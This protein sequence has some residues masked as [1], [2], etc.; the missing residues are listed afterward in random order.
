MEVLKIMERGERDRRLGISD[1]LRWLSDNVHRVDR[2]EE[3]EALPLEDGFG[4]VVDLDG[5]ILMRGKN[6]DDNMKNLLQMRRLAKR[7]SWVV[8]KTSR[9]VDEKEEDKK[10]KK[11]LNFPM[12]TR[13]NLDRLGGLLGSEDHPVW[14]EAG[15][16]K[17][18][19][20]VG[21]AEEVEK[22]LVDGRQ[23]L[24]VGSGIFDSILAE[25]LARKMGKLSGSIHYVCV[26]SG[27][28]LI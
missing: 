11:I 1:R 16:S 10:Q 7:A 13:G 3:V 22:T 27:F 15:L 12:I 5:V 14:V 20:R 28:S 8:V 18:T 19:G 17:L 6:F 21:F 2:L 23:V 4:M 25:K 9:W 26:G 24:V